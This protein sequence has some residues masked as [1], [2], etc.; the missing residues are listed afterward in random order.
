MQARNRGDQTQPE[1]VSGR[2]A[3]PFKPIKALEY[4]WI[5][6]RG[7]SWP[8]IGNG[9]NGSAIAAFCNFNCHLPGCATMFDGI[10]Y[11]IGDG[12]ENKVSITRN[13][14]SFIP[15][16]PQTYASFFSSGVI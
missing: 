4:V 12:I 16:A 14:Y 13:K 8:I 2:A 3:A 7:D 1:T 11:E 15:D 6:G 10:V 9:N 5:F